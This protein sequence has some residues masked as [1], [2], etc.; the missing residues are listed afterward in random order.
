[1]ARYYYQK[2]LSHAGLNKYRVV[3]AET[4]YELER[5]V[6][7]ITAQW[8][9]QWQ[10]I[11]DKATKQANEQTLRKRAERITALAEETHSLI[12]QFLLNSLSAKLLTFDSMRNAYKP[13]KPTPVLKVIKLPQKPQRSEERFNPKAGLFTRLFK[14]DA[15]AAYCQQLYDSALQK[16]EAKTEQIKLENQTF[17][18]DYNKQLSALAA[19]K[20]AY[21]AEVDAFE[22]DFFNGSTSA[23]ERYVT[24]QLEALEY[25]FPFEHEFTLD[26]DANSH[27]LLIDM[28]IPAIDDLPTL[29]QATYVK[30]RNCISEKS[31]SLTDMRKKCNAFTYQLVL[32]ALHRLYASIP[33]SMVSDIVLNG[34][35]RTIDKANGL[36]IT[37]CILSVRT[38]R[39]DF[40]TVN[41]QQ[42][43]PVA[44]FRH[45]KGIS[46]ASFADITPIAPI[47][48][49]HTDDKRFVEGYNVTDQLSDAVNLAAM[50]WLDFENLIREIF[51]QEFSQNGSEVH[52]TQAS[53][54]GGVDAVVFDPDP[55]KGGK[56]VIQAKRYTNVVGVSAVRDLYGTVMN[57]GAMKGILVTTANYG[58]DAYDFATGKPLTLMS[59]AELLYLL[60]KHGHKARID[61]AEAKQHRT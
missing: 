11:Q 50:D 31:F 7:A 41:L 12:D 38:S 60:D 40:S 15:H 34:R 17:Q 6:E 43:D 27:L 39:S 20:Q 51:E 45:N 46:A 52:I 35:V 13:S 23:F 55:I 58:K 10:R 37:P 48:N 26:Y 8:N 59:G 44:W 16:W 56:I 53:R 9:T 61:L 54:D 57:E 14:A 5:K 3:K 30:S 21:I 36:S 47:I 18:D 2:E 49:M 24:L 4:A 32:A 42:V 29:K 19:E 1:M 22:Y 25:P 28:F 33:D